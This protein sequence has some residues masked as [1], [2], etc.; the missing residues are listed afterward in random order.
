MRVL[1]L[2]PGLLGEGGESASTP[3]RIKD[4][5]DF[6]LILERDV[7][8]PVSVA[9]FETACG[10]KSLTETLKMT[11]HLPGTWSSI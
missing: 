11:W 3:I 9:Q 4:M 6:G 1:K 8:K 7:E 2:K 10:D 5:G